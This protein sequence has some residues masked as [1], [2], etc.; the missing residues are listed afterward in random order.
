MFGQP[1]VLPIDLELEAF[2]GTDWEAVK[3]TSG[4]LLARVHQLEKREEI[5]QKAYKK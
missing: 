5:L 1:A 3:S 2:L 4:L